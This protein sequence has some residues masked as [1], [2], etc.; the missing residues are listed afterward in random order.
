MNPSFSDTFKD[1]IQFLKR[2]QLPGEDS[3]ETAPLLVF[4]HLLG[5][6]LLLST[7][8]LMILGALREAGFVPEL[9]HAMDDVMKEFSFGIVFLL[10]VIVMPALEELTFRLW[11]MYSPL[12]FIV[13]VWLIAMFLSTSFLQV[14]LPFA[15]Y[16]VL[17]VA[18]L[19]TILMLTFRDA[20]EDGLV[21]LYTNYYGWLF[22]GAAAL[23]GVVH[24]VNF[25]VDARIL[26][27]A[28]L[29]VLP[30]LLLGMVLGYLRLRLGLVWAIALHA[31]Y[32]ALILSMAYT[33]MN[34]ETPPS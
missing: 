28:P 18:A 32:N 31:V 1:F 17:G 14:E 16:T 9:P 29:L 26:L 23:F 7:G 12:Y 10:A 30:Q 5:L 34:M 11:L 4:L 27:M 19:I 20:T 33:G 22:Y 15:G 6:S 13:S 8:V 3:V 21:R 2:P 25:D 24:L